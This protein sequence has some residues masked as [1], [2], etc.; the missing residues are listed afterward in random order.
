[1]KR[2]LLIF[3]ALVANWQREVC[4]IPITSTTV[5]VPTTESTTELNQPNFLGFK[6]IISRLHVRSDIRFR[7]ARTVVQSYV[8]NPYV[9]SERAE[10]EIVLPEDA[11]IS[12]FTIETEGKV[13]VSN[14]E[15]KAEAAEVFQQAVRQGQ[16]AGLVDAREGNVMAVQVSVEP[17]KKVLFTLTYEQLLQRQLGKYSQVINLNPKQLVDDLKI[18]VYINES[19][20]VVHLN[21]PELKQASNDVISQLKA[22]D[23]VRIEQNGTAVHV[24]YAPSLEEQRT[25][26]NESGLKGQF[27]V[28]YDVDRKGA[29]SDVQVMDGYMVHFFAPENLPTLPKH[30]VFVLDTSG[31]MMGD[32]LV[33]VKDAMVQIL[34][35]LSDQDRFSMLLF[36]TEV[37]HWVS[38]ENKDDR[39]LPI[40]RATEA[41]KDEAI[42]FVIDLKAEGGT[43][44]ND[45]LLQAVDVVQMGKQHFKASPVVVFLTDGQ[46]TS[47]ESNPAR[48]REALK[49]KNAE[50]RVPIYGLAFGISAAYQLLKDIASDNRAFARKIFAESD[51][52]IQLEDFYM[53][54]SNPL[55]DNVTFTYVGAGVKEHAESVLP[56]SCFYSGSEFVSVSKIDTDDDESELKLV[57]EGEGVQ[58]P[59]RFP[60]LPC[61]RPGLDCLPPPRPRIRTE[62]FIERLW[63]YLTIEKLLNDKADH[64]EATREE[65][66]QRATEIALEYNFVT[67]LTSLVVVKPNGKTL[68]ATDDQPLVL[69]PVGQQSSPYAGRPYRNQLYQ[70]AAYGS[71]L[72]THHAVFSAPIPPQSPKLTSM[73]TAGPI[74][75]RKTRPLPPPPGLNLRPAL[76]NN[77]PFQAATGPVSYTTT[78]VPTFQTVSDQDDVD[79][80]ESF[81]Q[82]CQPDLCTVTL[83]SKT[84]LRGNSANATQSVDD[85]ASI[86]FDD[87]TASLRVEGLCTWTLYKDAQFQGES[88]MF[89]LGEYKN[90]V[91]LRKLFKKVS[92]IENMGC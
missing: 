67:D 42:E 58:G 32:K 83:Y 16:T 43:N 4:S 46:A 44:I 90:A 75:R 8:K 21:V 24:E 86:G 82:V 35:D 7:Y 6:P 87:Q 64:G 65:R 25:F 9:T 76:I 39:P 20:P 69:T 85:L 71:P 12:N 10:F 66:E 1:M 73:K 28:Q 3:A 36:S 72:M 62:N 80:G 55:L 57:V 13:Y 88:K 70:P 50:T 84:L 81:P 27:I 14:V 74:L 78:T 37:S 92:S 30:I 79:G 48:I 41:L 52:T 29:E 59:V 26:D 89:G 47:G 22:N 54:I 63:A 23:N 33:Q 18:D 77:P 38:E 51:A 49:A 53:E 60:I 2:Y 5:V 17:S 68:N 56:H 61:F 91:H 19:L 11:F 34:S 15:K 45:A 31:S 40:Y